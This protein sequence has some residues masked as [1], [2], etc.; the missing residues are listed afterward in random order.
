MNIARAAR[1]PE[2]EVWHNRSAEG[3]LRHVGAIPLAVREVVKVMRNARRLSSN[4]VNA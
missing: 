3:V 1:T 4:A 2:G